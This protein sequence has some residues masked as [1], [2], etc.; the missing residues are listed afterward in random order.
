MPTS[1]VSSLTDTC[2]WLGV[3]SRSGCQ[4]DICLEEIG[5]RVENVS[6]IINIMI[7]VGGR[8]CM[9]V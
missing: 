3:C 6:S 1:V 2:V 8:T 7:G 5:L 4:K 9:I